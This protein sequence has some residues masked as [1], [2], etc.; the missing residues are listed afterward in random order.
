MATVSNNFTGVGVG[1]GIYVRAGEQLTTDLSGT[2]SATMVLERTFDGGASY[3]ELASATAPASA[4]VINRESKA[5]VYRFRCVV[6]TSG[7]AETTMTDVEETFQ[8]FENAEGEAVL[9][10]EED[11]VTAPL[12]LRATGDT[13]LAGALDVDGATTLDAVTVAETLDVTGALGADGGLNMAKGGDVASASTIDLDAVAGYWCD[14]TGTTDID[15]VTLAEGRVRWVRFADALTLTAGASFVM[16]GSPSAPD[17]QTAAGDWALM[18]GDAAG[19]VRVAAYTKKNGA[20]LTFSKS[21]IKK[22]Y[23]Q[24]AK[25]GATA[26][27]NVDVAEDRALLGHVPNS[28]TAC[29]LIIPLPGLNVGDTIVSFFLNGRI[30]SAGSTVTV[31]AELFKHTAG[32]GAIA[33]A[34]LGAI[35]QVSETG[36]FLLSA[37][38]AGKILAA[39]EGMG[40]AETFYVVVTVTTGADG[41]VEL[42]SAG[43]NL[44]Q[45]P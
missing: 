1:P 24:Q 10:F 42:I 7:T 3:E 5:A 19:V 12:K 33:D 28:K 39:P 4:T 45:A 25:E 32:A 43:I 41:E 2:F 23:N 17:I 29:T 30:E 37:A 16:P 8:S 26:G 27:W 22:I 21:G 44:T 40:D 34:S 36:D 20:P 15:T 14:I 13:A 38:S 35:T 11:G 18:V 9:T 31:D 6:F